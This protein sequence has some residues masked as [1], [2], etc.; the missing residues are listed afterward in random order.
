MGRILL[1]IVLAALLWYFISLKFFLG[2]AIGF[3]LG[4]NEAW[5][6]CKSDK[7]DKS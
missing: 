1:V 2:L 7:S 6:W 4:F 3:G 5:K